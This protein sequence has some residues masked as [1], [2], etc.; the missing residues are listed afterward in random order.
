MEVGWTALLDESFSSCRDM[1]DGGGEYEFYSTV[2]ANGGT[3]EALL[4]SSLIGPGGSVL[5]NAGGSINTFHDLGCSLTTSADT[6]ETPDGFDELG[7]LQR[8]AGIEA[9]LRKNGGNQKPNVVF[10]ERES[11]APHATNNNKNTGYTIAASVGRGRKNGYPAKN[12][13]AERRRRKKLNDRMFML[14]SVVPKVSKVISIHFPCSLC[15]FPGFG[16]LC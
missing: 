9:G 14:R 8:R 16:F 11:D 2:E 6:L 13:M 10:G 5:S 12:L 3:L 1:L 4:G 7:L 15:L